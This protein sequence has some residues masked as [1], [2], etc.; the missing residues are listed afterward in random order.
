M[1]V[2]AGVAEWTMTFSQVEVPAVNGFEVRLVAVKQVALVIVG[3]GNE[4]RWDDQVRVDSANRACSDNVFV[5]TSTDTTV[6][7]PRTNALQAKN[8]CAALEKA[9]L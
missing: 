1:L 6:R 4:A 9:E 3:C 5:E 7:A 8:M 2:K